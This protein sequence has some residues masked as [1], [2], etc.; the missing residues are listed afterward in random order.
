MTLTHLAILAQVRAASLTLEMTLMIAQWDDAQLARRLFFN[1]R[2]GKGLRLTRFGHQ[3]LQHC[4]AC[5]DFELGSGESLHPQ[6]MLFL[7][8]RARLP[9]YCDAERLA[10][11]DPLFAVQLR[12]VD[13]RVATLIEIDTGN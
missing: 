12:L 2:D 6:Q 5:F 10:V 13:G 8:R 4:F 7:D 1:Y 9:Y 3:V 11:Y